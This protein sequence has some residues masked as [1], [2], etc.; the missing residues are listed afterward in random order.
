MGDFTG[1]PP[2][3]ICVGTHEIHFDDCVAVARKAK[4][5]GVDVVLRQWPGMV[6]AFPILAPLFL[7][8]ETALRDNPWREV[9]FVIKTPMKSWILK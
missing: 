5:Q 2:L 7:E 9:D 3:H 6:H 1:F 8:A 4:G